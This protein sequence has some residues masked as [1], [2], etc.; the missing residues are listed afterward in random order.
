VVACRSDLSGRRVLIVEDELLVAMDLEAMLAEEGVEVIEVAATVAAAL[1]AL[2]EH[3]PDA[4]MLDLNLDGEPTIEVAERLNSRNIPFV[5]ATGF[6]ER[7]D[8][9]HSLRRAPRVEK[10]WNR[11]ELLSKLSAVLHPA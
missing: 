3:C 1:K 6:V 10:P 11:A 2:N 7:A 9:D 5:I 4:V 8:L